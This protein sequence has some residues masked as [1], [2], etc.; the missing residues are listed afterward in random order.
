MIPLAAT[1]S[2]QGSTEWP[3]VFISLE[4]RRSSGSSPDRIDSWCSS[5]THAPSHRSTRWRGPQPG[6]CS[7]WWMTGC[8]HYGQRLTDLSFHR[9]GRSSGSSQDGSP[10][11]PWNCRRTC[12]LG[13]PTRVRGPDTQRKGTFAYRKGLHSWG[14]RSQKSL[15]VHLVWIVCRS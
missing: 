15:I 9:S 4:K 7:W 6:I 3:R 1:L 10:R 11:N 13:C 12:S 14:Q 2:S 5:R 8:V